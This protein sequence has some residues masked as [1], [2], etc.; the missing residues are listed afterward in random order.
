VRFALM[1]QARRA[2]FAVMQI[3]ALGIALMALLLILLLRQ[4]LLIYL[5]FFH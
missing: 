1:A 4:D 5:M 3:T 2:G